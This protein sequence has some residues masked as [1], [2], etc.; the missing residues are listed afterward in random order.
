MIYTNNGLVEHCKKALKLKNV[1]MYGGILRTVDQ[2]Y[3]MLQKIYGNQSG[4]GYTAERWNYLHSL[5]GKDYYGVDCVGLI[6]SYYW[7]G[8]L[9]GGVGSPDYGKAGYPDV[10]AGGMYA[11]AKIKGRIETMPDKPGIIVYCRSHPHVGVYI[12]NGET[13][14]STLSYRGD[15][16]VKRKL[17]KLWEYW[18]ECPYISYNN[19]PETI[20][21]GDKVT[22][23]ESATTYAGVDTVIPEK[24]K[25]KKHIYTVDQVKKDRLLLKELYSWVYRKDLDKANK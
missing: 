8:K 25:G 14:E 23:K 4:T 18:F 21:V 22:I 7:S 2:Q 9:T 1:Y 17:D 19:K 5:F 16:I 12:G 15:G 24:Y 3:E 13:I 20:S 6:K 11:A 10:N